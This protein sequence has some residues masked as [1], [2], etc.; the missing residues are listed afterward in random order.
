MSRKPSYRNIQ[1]ESEAFVKF[2]KNEENKNNAD[3]KDEADKHETEHEDKTYHT[4]MYKRDEM[5]TMY[6]YKFVQKGNER[7]A[8][9]HVIKYL[10]DV[11]LVHELGDY[12]SFAKDI[13]VVYEKLRTSDEYVKILQK[14][15]TQ[16]TE[17]PYFCQNCGIDC[18]TEINFEQH[19]M[20]NRHRIHKLQAAIFNKSDELFNIPKG[21]VLY[22]NPTVVDGGKMQV[23]CRPGERLSM[24]ITMENICTDGSVIVFTR[25]LLLWDTGM[26]E[27]RDLR[28]G[29][30]VY[31]NCNIYPKG[32]VSRH[33][34]HMYEMA[35]NCSA[36]SDYGEHFVPL[37][38]YFKK[39]TSAG[40][41]IEEDGWKQDFVLR[42]LS[43]HVLGDLHEELKPRAPFAYPK[44]IPDKNI[45]EWIP[46]EKIKVLKKNALTS[47][48]K[49]PPARIPNKIRRYVQKEGGA[50][51]SRQVET[52]QRSELRSM[53]DC[54]LSI[55]TYTERMKILLWVEEI[56]MEIDIK[57]YD[58]VGVEMKLDMKTQLLILEV[59]GLAERRPSVMNCDAIDIFIHG[60]LTVCYTG[61]VH[62]VEET[63]VHLGVNRRLIKRWVDK[64][65]FDV[66][67]NFSRTN[68]WLQ[69]RA[70]S[71]GPSVWDV[72]FPSAT[73]EQ[74]EFGTEVTE[75]V[76]EREPTC[77]HSNESISTDSLPTHHPTIFIDK[78]VLHGKTNPE[79]TISPEARRHTISAPVPQVPKPGREH[80][81]L[82][83]WYDKKLNEEQKVAVSNIVKGTSRPAP[84]MIF[85]PPG[86]GKTVTVTEAIRQIYHSSQT[87]RILVCC[88]ENTAADI[89]MLKLISKSLSGTVQLKDI[90]RL[91]AV[92]RPFASIPSAIKDSKMYNF[93]DTEGEF[94]YPSRPELEKYRILIVTLSTSGRLVSASFEKNFFTH[95][96][97]DEGAH[98]IEPECIVPITGLMDATK[99]DT[100]P[101]LVISG[102][103]KQLGPVL[104]SRFSLEYGLDLSIMERLMRDFEQYKRRD[105]KAY[106]VRYITKLVRNY[107]SHDDIISIPRQLF[108]D[109]ELIACGDE[110]IRNAMLGWD[111][112]PNKKFPILFHSVFGKDEREEDSP[113]FFNRD[114]IAQVDKYLNKL[115]KEKKKGLQ[116]K[117]SDIGIISPY[118]KQVQKLREMIHLKK[119]NVKKGDITVKKGDITV[120]SV[121]EFQGQEFKVII[122][123]TVRSNKSLAYRDIDLQFNLGFLRN[124]K[125]F[126]VAI[127]RA[128]ALLIVVGNPITLEQDSHWKR[129]IDFC[130]RNGGFCGSRGQFAKSKGGKG[131]NVKT[132]TS[133]SAEEIKGEMD[134]IGAS[135]VALTEDPEWPARN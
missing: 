92:Y 53:L 50:A 118:R 9:R 102:D 97:I 48:T 77:C 76:E 47:G 103:P 19:T 40:K 122:I 65:R 75:T 109:N 26:F 32:A 17:N 94:F 101:Q 93:D 114:E 117:Q 58:L 71:M 121:E 60:E 4:D 45:K 59:P 129:F 21:V 100:C 61:I 12:F 43:L 85:G 120:G 8:F 3:N 1:R 11:K 115:L 113:S 13:Q 108:Y 22:S 124:P 128:R 36:P 69:H 70:A 134:E 91:C 51:Q 23:Q 41:P 79:F 82:K 131:G 126:N 16:S 123:S 111:G 25:H 30:P 49:L 63:T 132:E 31:R 5:R 56:Q 116:I 72:L 125:R 55:K 46:G 110:M 80:I 14:W 74:V 34:R 62:K 15:R 83:P 52:T 38:L 90:Y 29:G 57:N 24:T 68:L 88:P 28:K 96:F 106:N 27:L 130:D 119:Y 95:I 33:N 10:K 104:R 54:S 67:F 44:R 89:V 42:L 87:S 7:V 105:D 39:K 64:T 86:T 20:G 99:K 84:Y 35:I 6:D 112:L 18:Q 2:L 133:K 73:S 98:A 78:P 81:Q 127:T 37:A 135:Y 66:R 107:R